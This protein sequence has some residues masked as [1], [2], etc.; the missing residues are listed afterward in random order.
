MIK[1][2]RTAGAAPNPVHQAFRIWAV[3]RCIIYAQLRNSHDPPKTEVLHFLGV[4]RHRQ[5]ENVQAIELLRTFGGGVFAAAAIL[6]LL[7]GKEW[8]RS[9]DRF[10]LSRPLASPLVLR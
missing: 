6:V 8:T 7:L 2:I 4:L 10:L 1:P 3:P 5:S 9:F